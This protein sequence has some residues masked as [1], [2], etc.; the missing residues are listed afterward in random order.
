M[1]KIKQPEEIENP[2]PFIWNSLRVSFYT[3]ITIHILLIVSVPEDSFTNS[4]V[5]IGE[6][7]VSLIWIASGFWT[8]VVSIIHLTKFKEK[9]LAIT[10]LVLS[11]LYV[12]MFLAGITLGIAGV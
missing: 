12:M 3:M 2:H 5:T 1:V 10:S 11:S 4:E 7:L 8:F 9:G 6:S